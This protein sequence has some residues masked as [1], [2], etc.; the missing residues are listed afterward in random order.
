MAAGMKREDA[1]RVFEDW[2]RRRPVPEANKFTL[3]R[4]RVI[5]HRMRLGYSADDLILIIRYLHESDDD[6]ARWMQGKHPRNRIG[7]GGK[8]YLDL[9]NVLRIARLGARIEAAR[10]WSSGISSRAASSDRVDS[11]PF[12]L[13]PAPAT[14]TAAPPA[15]PATPTGAASSSF[16]FKVRT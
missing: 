7:S 8:A 12:R 5:Y 14:H 16:S 1:I 6:E 4:E 9:E 3:E 11:V 13:I 15:P 10:L 2:R